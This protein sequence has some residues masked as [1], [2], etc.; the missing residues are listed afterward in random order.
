[1]VRAAVLALGGEATELGLFNLEKEQLWMV[2]TADPSA[3]MASRRWSNVLHRGTEARNDR[4]H[5]LSQFR[6]RL[7]TKKKIS[8]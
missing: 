6:F 7:G 3:K 8:S 1:M 4:G 2:L 5:K